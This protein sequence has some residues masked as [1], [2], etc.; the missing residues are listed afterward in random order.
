MSKDS[1]PSLVL[2]VAHAVL[3]FS[4]MVAGAC[5]YSWSQPAPPTHPGVEHSQAIADRLVTI[6]GAVTEA[7]FALG[8]GAQVV[9][10]D[11]SSVYPADVMHLPK[12]GYQRTLSAEGIL[13]LRP[14]RIVAAEEAGPPHVLDQLRQAGIPIAV[15]PGPPSIAGARAKLQAIADALNVPQ[16]G[17]ALVTQLDDET[18][19][20]LAITPRSGKRPRVLFLY[21]RSAGSVLVA[22]TGT[23]PAA[24][25]DL[26]G[27]ENA[28]AALRG[29]KP[30]SAEALVAARPDI[31]L[32]TDRGAASLGG[33]AGVRMLPGVASLPAESQP[34]VRTLDDLLLLGFGPRT[35]QAIAALRRLLATA[36][37]AA[38]S[39]SGSI[40]PHATARGV[41]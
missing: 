11:T 10:V 32:L 12:V 30:Y 13:A 16:R 27:A 25:L 6:G 15:I 36:A 34:D 20:A 41:Q 1:S 23:A 38:T 17:A 19:Q 22:G 18:T 39:T 7:V 37:T 8:L 9:G 14:T 21:A 40:S 3:F 2:S 31:L 24:M 35:G 28:A 4:T 29:F 5:R 26:A 33:I